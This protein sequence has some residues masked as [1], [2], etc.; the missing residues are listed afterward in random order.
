MLQFMAPLGSY[1]NLP[2]VGKCIA[3]LKLRSLE[4]NVCRGHKINQILM[5]FNFTIETF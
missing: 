4:F 3:G 2:T 5:T 1:G